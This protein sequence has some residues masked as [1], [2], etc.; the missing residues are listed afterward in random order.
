[1]STRLPVTASDMIGGRGLDISVRFPDGRIPITF[2]GIGHSPDLK[3]TVLCRGL[4]FPPS[5]APELNP[6][7]TVISFYLDDP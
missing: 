2:E 1:M 7:N 6:T 3:V 4:R 5:N